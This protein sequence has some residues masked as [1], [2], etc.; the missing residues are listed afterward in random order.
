MDEIIL[1]KDLLGSLQTLKTRL[2]SPVTSG[3]ARS[4]GFKA[5]AREGQLS[6]P[7]PRLAQ[8]RRGRAEV[9]A[10]GDPLPLVLRVVGE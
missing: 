5:T 2:L 4:Y 6:G 8:W 1:S 3:Q 9:I 7:A 10:G